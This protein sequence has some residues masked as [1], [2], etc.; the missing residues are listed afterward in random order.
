MTAAKNTK[1][2]IEARARLLAFPKADDWKNIVY[3]LKLTK[4]QERELEITISTGAGRHRKI[5]D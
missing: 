2:E 3:R 1:A 5:S 4:T